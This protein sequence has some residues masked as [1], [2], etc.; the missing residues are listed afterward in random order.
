VDD[1]AMISNGDVL[2][3]SSGEPFK[4][5]PRAKNDPTD[6]IGSYR[7]VSYLGRGSFGKVRVFTG[8]ASACVR[9]CVFYYSRLR[10]CDA[11]GVQG[12][13]QGNDCISRIEVHSQGQPWHCKGCGTCH[14]RNFSVEVTGSRVRHFFTGS[15]RH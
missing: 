7:I 8:I 15:H 2:F 3:A 12:R 4:P 13:S 1:L 9:V 6:V 5:P 11:A 10:V 14:D